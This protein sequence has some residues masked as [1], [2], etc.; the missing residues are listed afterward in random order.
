LRQI[1]ACPVRGAVVAALEAGAIL[2]RRDFKEIC[3]SGGSL[4]PQLVSEFQVLRWMKKSV[5]N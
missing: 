4:S 5:R 1:C 3:L 2:I